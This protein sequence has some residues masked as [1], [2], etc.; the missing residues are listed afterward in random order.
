[1]SPARTPASSSAR[2]SPA[3]SSSSA[4]GEPPSSSLTALPGGT[5]TGSSL[6]S[7]RSR[8]WRASREP[9]RVVLGACGQLR[10]GV[11]VRRE[12]LEGGGPPGEHHPPGLVGERHRDGRSDDAA[13]RVDRVELQLGEVVE[14]V[15]QHGRG[16]PPRG[17]AAQRVK[18]PRSH[19]ARDRPGASSR[20]PRGSPRR[21]RTAAPRSPLAARPAG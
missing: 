18:R 17:L 6:S 1:M 21:R 7:E 9:W 13:E 14:A 10:V 11:R 15:E 12:A 16:A 4:R 19:A 2:T 3:T 20:A 5:R 8:W